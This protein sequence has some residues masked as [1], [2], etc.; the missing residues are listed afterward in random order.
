MNYPKVSIC[1]PN[2]NMGSVLGDCIESCV[3]QQVDGLEIIVSDN[4]SDDNS[5]VVA[6]RFADSDS[7]VKIYS[8]PRRLRLVDNWNRA[9]KLSSGEYFLLLCADDLLLPKAIDVV[10]HEIEKSKTFSLCSGERIDVDSDGAFLAQHQF[11]PSSMRKDGLEELMILLK[12]NHFLI[13]QT[14]IRRSAWDSAGGFDSRFD[15]AI[16]VHLRGKLLLEGDFSYVTKPVLA[17]RKHPEAVTASVIKSLIA[18]FDLLRVKLDLL[19]LLPPNTH[20]DQ[21]EREIY[22]WLARYCRRTAD[23]LS[24]DASLKRQY[25]L[26]SKVFGERS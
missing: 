11:Y 26:L 1:I 13:S 17:Y 4:C 20:L 7:R 23:T 9:V 16:D 3:S 10:L 5:L 2:L 21:R 25:I 19:G 22:E 12:S 15:W 24:D 8:A 18:P 14:L 6:Q